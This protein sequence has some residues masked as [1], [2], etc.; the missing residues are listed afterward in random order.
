MSKRPSI[1]ELARGI[2]AGNRSAL[3]RA[4]T[5]VESTHRR[6]QGEAQELLTKLLPRTGRAQRIGITGVPGVGKSTF[7]EAFGK[8]L[9]G[10][11]HKVA[12]LAIDPTSG[13][14]GGSI[15]GDKTRMIELTNDPNAFV[16]PSPT[17]GTLGGV[18][19][20]TREAMLL[21][22]AAGFDVVLIETVGVGQS[23][24]VV[25]DM[26]D[27]FLVL[28]LPGAGDELQGIKRGI[29]EIAD[30]ICVNKA[31]GDNKP[32]AIR[33][34]REYVNALH[35]MTPSSP[36]WQVPVQL[37]AGLK[38]EG[39]P[40]IWDQIN[41]HKAAL[42]ASGERETK[43]AAQRTRWMWD[44]IDERLARAFRDHPGVRAKLQADEADVANGKVSA[45]AAAEDLLHLFLD[46]VPSDG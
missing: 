34:Q 41:K 8:M 13:R 15:L 38:G 37:C 20:A 22:E 23:E 28:M 45:T 1:D 24:T 16:R 18:A 40:E 35:I 31:D 29:L 17:A 3:A 14:T 30:M 33:A 7:I 39:L 4:I 12:V 25:A 2:E 6:H 36:N 10:S 5:L 19:R 32:K 46:G 42:S 43:R 21:C 9:T 44:M 11:G 27:F 26:V